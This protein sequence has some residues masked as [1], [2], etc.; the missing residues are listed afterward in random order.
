MRILDKQELKYHYFENPNRNKKEMAEIEKAKKF[1]ND[2][3]E[4][5]INVKGLYNRCTLFDSSLYHAAHVF[6]GDKEEEDRLIFVNVIFSITNNG[7]MLK[8]PVTESFRF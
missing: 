6:T 3:F 4:E 7:K 2:F 8:Y 5:T 1:N